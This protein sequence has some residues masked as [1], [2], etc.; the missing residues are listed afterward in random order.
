LPTNLSTNLL[1][2]SA[3]P[4]QLNRDER[5]RRSNLYR[6]APPRKLVNLLEISLRYRATPA[7]HALTAHI[8]NGDN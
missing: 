4:A 6:Q 7:C 3:R 5:Y 8:K 1:T 2:T